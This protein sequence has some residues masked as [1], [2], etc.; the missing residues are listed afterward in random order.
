LF[1]FANGND[2]EYYIGSADWMTRNFDRRVEAI[3]PVDD[4]LLHAKLYS[5]LATS[6]TDNREAWDLAADGTYTQR[7]PDGEPERATQEIFL[8]DPWG[9]ASPR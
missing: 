3:V 9:E 1:Y 7:A 8:R 2:P 4:V 5:L 6:L